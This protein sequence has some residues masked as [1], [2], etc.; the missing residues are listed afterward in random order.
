[1]A[2]ILDVVMEC[3]CLVDQMW[4]DLIR[5][6]KRGGLNVIQTYVFWNVHE[7]VQGQV[8]F[9]GKYSKII[10][11]KSEGQ[12]SFS[13]NDHFYHSNELVIGCLQYNFTGRYDLVRFIKLIQMNKMYVTLRLGPF[14]QAEWNHGWV[15]Y[16][17][18]VAL[19]IY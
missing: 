12:E 3:F 1:M 7:P 16:Y 14:I 18:V 6:A 5:K 13:F 17:I 15:I 19:G 10:M 11:L 9:A 4:P 2:A 8:R